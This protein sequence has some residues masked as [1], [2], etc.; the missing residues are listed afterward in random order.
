MPAL[1]CLN[2]GTPFD[3]SASFCARCAQRTDT[4]RLTLADV[5]RDLLQTFV[6][7]ERGP[8]AF[9]W[10]LLTRP[11]WVAHDYVQGKRRRHYG[12]FA[13]LLVL[14]GFT[15][16]AI[17][18]SGFQVM[19]QDGLPPGPTGLL[20]R[21]FNLLLL[22][23]LPLLGLV[24]ALVFHGSGRTLPEHLVLCAY[25]LSVRAVVLVLIA[26]LAYASA[27]PPQ[28]RWVVAFWVAW[29]LYFGWSASQ[30][31]A[32]ERAWNWTRGVVAAG[33]GHA[34][35]VGLLFGGS[36]AWAAWIKL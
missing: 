1:R 30:F 31:Y 34:A 25:T 15:A 17:N 7:V 16:L 2:C 24:C 22:V 14:V 23:Q 27:T 9:A 6:N 33:L 21:H 36:A 29:Y 32:G 26:P 19:S 28:P 12:P 18:L 3:A 8:V 4:A 11:G 20:Q 35:T 5:T 13:T 10:A